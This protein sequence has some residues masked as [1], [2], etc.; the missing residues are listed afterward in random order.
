MITKEQKELLA[1][2]IFNEGFDY[3]F[4]GYSS[5]TEIKDRKFRN[6]YDNFIEAREDFISYLKDSGIDTDG[7]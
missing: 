6:L 7:Y 2:K 5:W 3:C 1:S 4:T